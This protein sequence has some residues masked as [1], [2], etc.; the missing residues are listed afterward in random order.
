ME[1]DDKIE[2][3]RKAYEYIGRYTVNFQSIIFELQNLINWAFRLL[4]LEPLKIKGN[5]NGVEIVKEVITMTNIF[6]DKRSAMDIL[7]LARSVINQVYNPKGEEKTIVDRLLNEIKTTIELRNDLL[8]G[9]AL[10]EYTHDGQEDF[11]SFY[12]ERI[13]RTGSGV[14]H[15][16]ETRFIEEIKAK[17]DKAKDLSQK[18]FKLSGYYFVKHNG[19][20]IPMSLEE[21]LQQ[22]NPKPTENVE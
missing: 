13:R 14:A 8:H 5:D 10:I 3:Q 15:I 19:L 18:I 4:G 9:N 16:F 7:E 17:A 20:A 6:Y 12:L 1:Y 21:Y 11:S 2:S 22:G